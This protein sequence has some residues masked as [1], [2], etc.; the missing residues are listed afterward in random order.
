MFHPTFIDVGLFVGTIGI[1]FTLFLLFARVFPVIAQAETKSIL[2]LAGSQ[3]MIGAAAPAPPKEDVVEEK[4]EEPTE[5]NAD[6]ES[7]ENDKEDE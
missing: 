1:F 7:A 3:Y 6:D 2:K 4:E 5:D